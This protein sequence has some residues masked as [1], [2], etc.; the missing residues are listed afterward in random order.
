MDKVQ[1]AVKIQ[2]H[3]RGYNTRKLLVHVHKLYHDILF[4][5]DGR[6][7]NDHEV[8]WSRNRNLN[9]IHQCVIQRPMIQKRPTK[10]PNESNPIEQNSKY[11]DTISVN[12]S[13]S[14]DETDPIIEDVDVPQNI[15]SDLP[16]QN[17][18][19]EDLKNTLL[20]RKRDITLELLWA[21]Q[22]IESRVNYLTVKQNMLTDSKT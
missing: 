2:S 21:Q 7:N 6:R 3:W 20:N 5:I 4:E 17:L 19:D 13:L 12:T 16:D 18:N 9:S 15:S 8:F 22:A 11:C 14:E 10:I 1:A